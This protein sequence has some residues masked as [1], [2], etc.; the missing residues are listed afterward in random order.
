MAIRF[1]K[2]E[3]SEKGLIGIW[4]HPIQACIIRL[5]ENVFANYNNEIFQFN[6]NRTFIFGE[7]SKNGPLYEV[8]GTW[9]LSIDKT[10]IELFF[11]NGSTNSI[12]IHDYDEKTFATTSVEGNNFIYTKE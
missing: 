1:F 7:Y 4:K 6:G 12:D 8:K 9:R 2:R 5:N 11:D 3:L 10:R